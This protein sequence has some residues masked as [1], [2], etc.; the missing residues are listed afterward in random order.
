[1][2]VEVRTA[3]RTH[4]E[5]QEFQHPLSATDPDGDHPI[6]VAEV[7]AIEVAKDLERAGGTASRVAG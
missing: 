2:V 3:V 5:T 6:L 4:M 7:L 1:M